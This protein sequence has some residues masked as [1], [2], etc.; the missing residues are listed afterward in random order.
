MLLA[1]LLDLDPGDSRLTGVLRQAVDRLGLNASIQI[2]RVL[3]G[4]FQATRVS[5]QSQGA[6]PLRTLADLERPIRHAALPDRVVDRSLAALHR[7]AEVEGALHGL[8]PDQVHF[9]EVGAVDTVVDVVGVV[10]LVETLGVDRV[11]HGPVPVG[12]GRVSGSHGRVGVPAPATLELLRDVPVYGGPEESEVTTPTGALLLTE[13]AAGVGPLPGLVPRAVGY[14]AGSR[15]LTHGPNLLRAVL[16]EEIASGA[17]GGGG[18]EAGDHLVLLETNLD[19]VTGEAVAH[20]QTVLLA[21]GA[22]DVWTSPVFM[23]KGRPGVLLSVLTDR[24][25][26]HQLADIVFVES[27]TFGIRRRDVERHVLER[28]FVPVTVGGQLIHVKVGRRHGAVV[29]VA[30]E[31]EDAARAAGELGHPLHQVMGAAVEAAMRLLSD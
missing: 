21:S 1:A 16:G 2:D 3:E 22:R 31:F 12:S 6:Q 25:A 18:S 28:S 23:K 26:E 14:G 9:H 13:L 19:D 27:G 11:E 4:G 10:L 7:L 24:R 17:G 8:R 30:A 29:T 20:L 15:V 5:V